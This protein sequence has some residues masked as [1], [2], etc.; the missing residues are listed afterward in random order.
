MAEKAKDYVASRMVEHIFMT[1]KVVQSERYAVCY[2][3]EGSRVGQLDNMT[4]DEWFARHLADT[5]VR[6]TVEFIEAQEFASP[7]YM[8]QDSDYGFD[9]GVNTVLYKLME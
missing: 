8:S 6:A 7:P 2:C 3:G 1:E 5:A 4:P 9:S